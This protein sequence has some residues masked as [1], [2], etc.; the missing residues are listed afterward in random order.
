[1]DFKKSWTEENAMKVLQHP[2]VD[3]KLWA[4]AVEW[5]MLHGSENMKS[6]LLKASG[7][8]TR[9]CFPEMQAEGC[10]QDGRP[11]YD[12]SVLAR[13]LGAN[14]EEIRRILLEKEKAHGTRHSVDPSE[15]CKVQ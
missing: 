12:I 3:S 7:D 2:T 15:V 13:S 6:L 11:C 5:L 14:E 8:A 10:T 1:M 4:E 9:R